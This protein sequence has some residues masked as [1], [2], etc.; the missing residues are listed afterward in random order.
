MVKN[1]DD[2]QQM[3]Q[4]LAEFIFR[5]GDKWDVLLDIKVKPRKKTKN[6]GMYHNTGADLFRLSFFCL[7]GSSFI[8]LIEKMKGDELR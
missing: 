2:E 4:E 1:K 7:V 3:M 8:L 5:F 6:R